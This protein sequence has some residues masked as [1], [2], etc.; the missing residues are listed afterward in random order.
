MTTATADTIPSNPNGMLAN[1]RLQAW[2]ERNESHLG[3]VR[4]DRSR[5]GYYTSRGLYYLLGASAQLRYYGGDTP[6]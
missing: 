3:R 4:R 2:L 6:A 1:E 5:D